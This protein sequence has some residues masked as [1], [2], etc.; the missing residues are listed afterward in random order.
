VKIAKFRKVS[1]SKFF[2]VLLRLCASAVKIR[3]QG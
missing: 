1:L 2:A 3:T